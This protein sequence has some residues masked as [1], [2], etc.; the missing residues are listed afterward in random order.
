MS[1]HSNIQCEMTC[2]VDMTRHG[3]TRHDAVKPRCP[4]RFGTKAMSWA[5]ACAKWAQL[6]RKL[7]FFEKSQSI[8]I[9]FSRSRP[10][11]WTPDV[12]HLNLD[13]PNIL[14]QACLW[15]CHLPQNKCKCKAN[16]G[17]IVLLYQVIHGYQN[18]N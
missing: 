13:E 14:L 2:H 18:R 9:S 16:V 7:S 12:N 10:S 3:L 17:D 1:W 8:S 5:R 6:R 4:S 15:S 11:F